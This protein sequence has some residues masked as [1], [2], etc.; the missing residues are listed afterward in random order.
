MNDEVHPF[1]PLFEY[2]VESMSFF[3]EEEEEEDEE[4][5]E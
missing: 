2:I 3:F 4:V 1:L 5:S